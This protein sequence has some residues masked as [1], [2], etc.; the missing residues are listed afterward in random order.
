MPEYSIK[1][2]SNDITGPDDGQYT[3]PSGGGPTINPFSPAPSPYP[4]VSPYPPSSTPSYHPSPSPYPPSPSPYPP[5]PYPPAGPPDYNPTPRP[6]AKPAYGT[7]PNSLEDDYGGPTAPN[8]SS[9]SGFGS[10]GASGPSG[11]SGHDSSEE[12]VYGLL[13]PKQ[14]THFTEHIIPAGPTYPTYNTGSGGDSTYPYHHPSSTASP[15]HRIYSERLDSTI[16]KNKGKEWYFGIPPGINNLD[17]NDPYS[18]KSNILGGTIRAHIQN[19]DLVPVHERAISPS[20]ALKRDE[21]T[22]ARNNL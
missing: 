20:E 4:S 9:G 2:V 1:S 12:K 7:T 18:P 14:D 19:I 10:S 8:Y 22:E 16:I 11:P 6:F 3:G 15:D 17:T 5:L 13:P 21:E